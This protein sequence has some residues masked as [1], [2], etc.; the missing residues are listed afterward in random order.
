MHRITLI[1]FPLFLLSLESCNTRHDLSEDEIYGIINEIIADDTLFIRRVCWKFIDIPLKGEYLK[2]FTNEDIEFNKRQ[3]QI[4][5]DLEIKSNKLKWFRPIDKAFI[6]A[7]V[8]TICNEGILY[9]FSFPIIAK[10]R[11]KVLIEI[12]QDCNCMLVS[13][14]GK[15]LYVKKNGHWVNTKGFDHWISILFNINCCQQRV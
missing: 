9:H 5:K 6:F 10:D 7:D 4:F 13:Q 1:L 2:E 15:R 11:Q 12:Y 8:D 3:R 14:S